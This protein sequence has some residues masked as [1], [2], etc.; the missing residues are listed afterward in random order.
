MHSFYDI[1]FSNDNTDNVGRRYG[2]YLTVSKTEDSMDTKS[3]ENVILNLALCYKNL[4]FSTLKEEQQKEILDLYCQEHHLVLD[5]TKVRL[6]LDLI[7]LSLGY[8]D[9]RFLDFQ[10]RLSKLE[11]KDDVRKLL[12]KISHYF[13]TKQFNKKTL[14][15]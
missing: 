4:D 9:K 2:V 3:G 8:N 10:E 6:S 14:E 7:A 12:I 15:F 13:K 11:K 5:S 1:F